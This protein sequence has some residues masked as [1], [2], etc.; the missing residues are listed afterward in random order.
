MKT[1]SLACFLFVGWAFSTLF[2]EASD[3]AAK[4]RAVILISVDGLSH[5]YLNDPRAELPTIRELARQGAVADGGMVASFPTVTWPN[6]TTLVT[7]VTPAR[8]GVLG[9]SYLDRKTVK[10]VT[11]LTD[12]VYDKEDLVRVPTVYDAAAGAGL[13]TAGIVWP[14]TRNAKNLHWNV[15]D[16]GRPDDWPTFATSDWLAEMREAGLPVDKHSLWC[17]EASGGVQRD[18]LYTRML[19]HVWKHHRPHLVLIHLVEVDHVEHRFGPNSPEAYWAVS[20]ADDRV[21]DIVRTVQESDRADRTTIIVASDH[22]FFPIERDIRLNVL[23]KKLTTASGEP[24]VR[25]LSQGGAAMI[26]ILDETNR[27]ELTARIQEELK[28]VEGV[29]KV[30][31]PSEFASV[32]QA[33]PATDERSPDLWVAVQSGYTVTDSNEG[34][35]VIVPRSHGGTHGYSPDHDDLLALLVL[36]GGKVESGVKLGRVSN[37]DV[38]PTIAELLDVPFPGTEGRPLPGVVKGKP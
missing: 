30:F 21:R 23:F 10:S 32:G 37:L 26:Y 16:M 36:S 1:T 3:P 11:L 25:S 2:A 24:A 19:A 27:K 22:G 15:P 28:G 18:W 31:A 33:P 38:A 5:S 17:K 4:D 12:P 13:K 6:H 7:G 34:E 35:A 29:E 9:N 14:A 20:Y 8:H